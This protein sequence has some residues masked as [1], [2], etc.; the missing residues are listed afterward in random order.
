MT[1]APMAHPDAQVLIA[2]LVFLFLVIV[3]YIAGTLY[4]KHLYWKARNDATNS[5]RSKRWE[6]RK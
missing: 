1:E 5:I 6:V 3:A 4:E 2:M